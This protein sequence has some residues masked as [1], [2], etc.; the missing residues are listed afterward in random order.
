MSY[1]TSTIRY[2]LTELENPWRSTLIEVTRRT[3][4]I[5]NIDSWKTTHRYVI[6]SII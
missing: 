1:K 4:H 3:L 2:T 5:F 6:R